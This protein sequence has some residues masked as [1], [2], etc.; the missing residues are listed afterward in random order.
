MPHLTP[1]VLA[2]DIA[3]PSLPPSLPP[4]TSGGPDL[5]QLPSSAA[6]APA[7]VC[8]AEKPPAVIRCSVP[9]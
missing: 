2:G 9:Q 1:L 7:G 3:P 5:Q 4:F 6:A 8:P